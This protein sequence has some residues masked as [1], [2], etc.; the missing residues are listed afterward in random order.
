VP[1]EVIAVKPE[2]CPYGQ[3]ECPDTRPYNTHQIIERPEIQMT[4]R[5]LL[6]GTLLPLQ[7]DGGLVMDVRVSWRVPHPWSLWQ[8]IMIPEDRAS[9]GREDLLTLG[10]EWQCSSAIVPRVHV[11]S[12][13]GALPC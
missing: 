2:S 12:G 9:C 5:L 3:T 10:A 1:T 4:A 7:P 6:L 8:A 11:E 13:H